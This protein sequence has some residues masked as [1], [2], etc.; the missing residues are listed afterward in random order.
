MSKQFY[1][2]K[3][4]SQMFKTSVY[5]VD[6]W[7]KNGQLNCLKINSTVRISD[8]NIAE[9]LLLTTKSAKTV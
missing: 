7:I 5:T 9:F 3:E 4:I 6:N 1:T 2:R 8:T